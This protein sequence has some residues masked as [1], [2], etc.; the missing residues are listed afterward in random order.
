MQ[1]VAERLG[2]VATLLDQHSHE[3]DS[4]TLGRLRK[5]A[6]A[7]S[8]YGDV[9]WVNGISVDEGT[10]MYFAPKMLSFVDASCISF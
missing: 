2:E 8:R 10:T 9:P 7:L 4:E 3:I 1:E 6:T 5:R